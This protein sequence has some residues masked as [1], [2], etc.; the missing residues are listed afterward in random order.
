MWP[1]YTSS[2]WT[3][4]SRDCVTY[5]L[6]TIRQIPDIM[7]YFR[8]SY[9]PDELVLPT[10]IANSEV[11]SQQVIKISQNQIL[12][13]DELP[14]IHHLRYASQKGSTVAIFDESD[15]DQIQA[16]GKLFVRKLCSNKSEKLCKMLH[17]ARCSK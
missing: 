12:T 8:Y 4:L 1:V 13:F 14:A 5:I 17:A 9:A 6:E 15:F 11:F 10:I 16:S 2:Q 7:R 3:A